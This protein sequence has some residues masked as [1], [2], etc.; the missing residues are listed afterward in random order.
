M[1]TASFF[2]LLATAGIVR[3]ISTGAV[4]TI[5]RV[6]STR[7]TRTWRCATTSNWTLVTM[8]CSACTAAGG[9]LSVLCFRNKPLPRIERVIEQ[10]VG[11]ATRG[12]GFPAICPTHPRSCLCF[13]KILMQCC[14]CFRKKMGESCLC[15]RKKWYLCSV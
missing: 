7:A 9:Y 2:P 15:F 5:G 11:G 8:K 14:L 6:R 4:A 3:T 12:A 1:A 10:L 13:R